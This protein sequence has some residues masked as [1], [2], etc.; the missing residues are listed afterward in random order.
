MDY[1][2]AWTLIDSM[3]RAFDEALVERTTGGTG[4]GGA[5]LTP[6]GVDVLARYRRLEQAVAKLG[7]SDLKA[8]ER[9]A[10]PEPGPKV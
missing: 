10:L 7:R 3:N 8:L 4:G 2:R 6:F 1:K 9:H 5:V